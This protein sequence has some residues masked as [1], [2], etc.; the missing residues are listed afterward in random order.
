MA[1]EDPIGGS[2][3]LSGSLT[4]AKEVTFETNNNDS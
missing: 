2:I 4:K 1:I 3:D